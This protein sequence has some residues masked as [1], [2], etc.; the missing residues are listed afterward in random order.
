MLVKCP[1]CPTVRELTRNRGD[2][3]R[4]CAAQKRRDALNTNNIPHRLYKDPKGKTCSQYLRVCPCGDKKWVGYMPDLNTECQKCASSRLGKIMA[5]N[6][7]KAEGE[8]VRYEHICSNCKKHRWLLVSPESRKTT[9]CKMCSATT[10]GKANK[11]K[12]RK[13]RAPVRRFRICH[14]CGDTKE[15]KTV[16][17][18][19]AKLC[20]KC[21]LATIDY[22]ARSAKSAATRVITQKTRPKP[23]P[24]PK[25]KKEKKISQ[26]VIDRER[27]INKEH[28]TAIQEA[29]KNV[30]IPKQ[31]L[32]DDD[33]I[34]KFLKTKQPSVILDDG[35]M[36]YLEPIA[37]LG[38]SA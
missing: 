7:I 38:A 22:S 32:S 23:K 28:K 10:T 8:H 11:G 25:P 36:P 37:T 12:E 9:L 4:P 20:R 2:L 27:K 14:E 17:E 16:S 5:K 18:T 21:S 31:N 33:M 30:K 3:C 35:P 6:N 13:V 24:K 15:V 19:K 29:K 26:R 34:K 1:N